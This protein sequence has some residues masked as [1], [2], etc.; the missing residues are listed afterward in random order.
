MVKMCSSRGPLL[1]LPRNGD[2]GTAGPVP[3][4]GAILAAAPLAD[5]DAAQWRFRAYR[6]L[7]EE[8]SRIRR[9]GA[10][11]DSRKASAEPMEPP[12]PVTSIVCRYSASKTSGEGDGRRVRARK[13]LQSRLSVD[14]ITAPV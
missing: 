11:E 1:M 9:G 14:E 3:D 12:A 10:S 4:A 13:L 2:M 7:S 8:S 5:P 6:L